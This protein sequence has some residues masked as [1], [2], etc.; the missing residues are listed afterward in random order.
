MPDGNGARWFSGVEEV[1]GRFA[2]GKHLIEFYFWNHLI[3]TVI[4]VFQ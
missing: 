3:H 1:G 4:S 2:L